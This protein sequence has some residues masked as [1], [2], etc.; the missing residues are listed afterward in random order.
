M[1]PPACSQYACRLRA[2]VRSLQGE[3]TLCL[4]QRSTCLTH[5]M[6]KPPLKY[7]SNSYKTG[8]DTDRVPTGGAQQGGTVTDS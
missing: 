8:P 1:V 3:C 6:L 7:H 2:R 4:V 5:C